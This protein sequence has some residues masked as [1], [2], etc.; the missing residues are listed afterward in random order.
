MNNHF[1]SFTHFPIKVFI[2]N[3]LIY[4]SLLYCKKTNT[5]RH[6][7]KNFSLFFSQNCFLTII[8]IHK[9][10]ILTLKFCLKTFKFLKII[11]FFTFF[12]MIPTLVSFIEILQ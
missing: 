5:L 3:F 12:F 1:I 6:I 8:L 4:K 11:K 7:E 2:F 9:L 10:L